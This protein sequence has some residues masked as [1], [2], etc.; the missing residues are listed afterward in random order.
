MVRIFHLSKYGL[1]L[2]SPPTFPTKRDAPLATHTSFPFF[3]VIFQLSF[4]LFHE[5]ASS[6]FFKSI[7]ITISITNSVSKILGLTLDKFI[8]TRK[9][10][11]FK[12]PKS[13]YEHCSPL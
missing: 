6:I 12:V 13:V 9:K 5:G 11:S 2:T 10:Y 3:Q 7:R 8:I 4:R 1:F